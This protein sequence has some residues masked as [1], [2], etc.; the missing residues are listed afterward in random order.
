MVVRLFKNAGSG[1]RSYRGEINHCVLNVEIS[2][3]KSD[4]NQIWWDVKFITQINVLN[5]KDKNWK[6][7]KTTNDGL[8]SFLNKC[9]YKIIILLYA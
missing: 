4:S 2:K 5:C 8:G 1:I 7:T 3:R 6:K 9:M